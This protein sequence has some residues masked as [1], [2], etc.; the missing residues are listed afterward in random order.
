[1]SACKSMGLNDTD[2]TV[3]S[4]QGYDGTVYQYRKNKKQNP[5]LKAGINYWVKVNALKNMDEL[6]NKLDDEATENFYIA[7]TDY[8]K[9]EQTELVMKADAIKAAREKA[10]VLAA[11]INEKVGNALPSMSQPK[12]AITRRDPF[13]E[14]YKVK[15]LVLRL[16]VMNL[17]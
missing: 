3:Q 8:S 4:Y 10:I 11:A 16:T 17:R 14:C 5:D 1:M 15:L 9:R 12:V 7:K 6:V 13:T 2:V